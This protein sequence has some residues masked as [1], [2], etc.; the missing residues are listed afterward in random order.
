MSLFRPQCA[1]PL[2]SED[3]LRYSE[4]HSID[5]SI[6]CKSKEIFDG[7]WLNCW[8]FHCHKSSRSSETRDVCVLDLDLVS[9]VTDP[10]SGAHLPGRTWSSSVFGTVRGVFGLLCD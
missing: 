9:L 8:Q 2:V 5:N 7:F 4:G 1:V 6:R 3:H 10:T